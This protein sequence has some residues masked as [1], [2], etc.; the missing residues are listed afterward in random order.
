MYQKRFAHLLELM[1]AA[2]LDAIAINPG[3]SLKYLTGLDFHLMER[4]I[5]LLITDKGT[6]AMVLPEL[7][8]SRAEKSP[9]TAHLFPYNDNPTNWQQSFFEATNYLGIHAMKIGVEPTRL[10]FLE[11]NYLQNAARQ[12]AMVSGAEVFEQIRI[13]KDANEI[14]LMQKAAQIA[15]TG[16]KNT[17]SLVKPG[18]T[19]KELATELV[20]QC[21]RAGGDA[22]FPFNPI[23]SS[24]PNSADPHATP[25]DRKVQSGELL[26]FDWGASYEGYAS[27]ITRTFAVGEPDPEFIKIADIVARAN[28]AGRETGRPGIPAGDVDRSTRKVIEEAG[29][30]QYF[31][32]RTGHGLGME[33]HESPYMFS[34]NE[35]L[36]EEGMVYT[37]EPGIYLS[38]KGGIRIEDDV[39]VNQ[40]GSFSLS[41]LERGLKVIG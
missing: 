23:V 22:E 1:Q 3:H 31:T 37:V 17:L 14:A 21:L 20:L 5:V 16:L 4:P 6:T 7:E 34:E 27:D 25:T 2:Q 24:G 35:L 33:G 36:L 12:A 10:R 8:V 38:G 9:V 30:G 41:T 29:Y 15:E 28:L 18:V 13:I 40:H 19:E 11:L 39:V 26:L 32:H